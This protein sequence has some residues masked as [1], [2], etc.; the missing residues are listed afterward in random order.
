MGIESVKISKQNRVYYGW[1]I[2]VGLFFIS[3]AA[4]SARF[5]FSAFF[6][7]LCEDLGWSRTLLSGAFTIHMVFY[8][9][10]SI[11]TGRLIDTMGGRWTICI[12]GFFVLIGL[13][14]LSKITATWHFYLYYGFILSIGI[15]MTYF[16]PN[17]TIVRKWFIKRAGLATSLGILGSGIA[18]AIVPRF[19]GQLCHIFGW[20]TAYLICGVV[21]GLI[22]MI[23]SVA[24]I[25]KQP[26]DMGLKPDGEDE[27]STETDVHSAF[28]EEIWTLK[29]ALQT[30]ALWLMVIAYSIIGFGLQGAITQLPIWGYDLGMSRQ[31]CGILMLYLCL[32]ACFT[33]ILGGWL[34]D[35]WS[36]KGVIVM[37]GFLCALAFIYL[38]FF[39]YSGVNQLTIGAVF[40]GMSYALPM[41]LWGP[42]VGD[43]YGR[44]SVGIIFGF[45]TFGAGIIGGS[46]AVLWGWIYD[47]F[48]SYFWGAILGAVSYFMSGLLIW[49]MKPPEKK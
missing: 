11:L 17:A 5:S 43:L 36:R 23:F 4:S 28:S 13:S 26:E 30:P 16:I 3:F 48:G 37:H 21:F 6:P 20:R 38:A 47:T 49:Y 34:G 27:V 19:M 39:G 24:L 33:R 9:C 42:F 12:G 1:W 2:V 46:G 44:L 15:N 10:I 18:V 22:I 14:L 25:R 45:L 35:R 7:F 40:L 31:E 29:E 32:P 41:G 8:A